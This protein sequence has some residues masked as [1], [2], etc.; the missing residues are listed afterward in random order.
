MAKID[1]E[2]ASRHAA[3]AAASAASG[4]AHWPGASVEDIGSSRIRDGLDDAAPVARESVELSVRG[5]IP[6]FNRPGDLANLLADMGQLE[7]SGTDAEVGAEGT[8]EDSRRVDFAVHLSLVV[9]DNAST[10]PIAVDIGSSASLPRDIA[11]HVIRSERNLGGS[12]GF[13]AGLRQAVSEV[14]REPGGVNRH[15]FVWL[16]DSD[17]R[18]KP[19]TLVELVRSMLRRP[20]ACAV[21]SAVADPETGRVFEVGGRVSRR[22]GRFHPVLRGVGGAP[23]ETDCEYAAACSVLVRAGA[24]RRTGLMPDVFLNADDVDWFIRM[25]RATG[26]RVLASSRS[27]VLH[28]KFDRFALAARYYVARNA[29]GPLRTLELALRVKV[30]RGMREVR[31]AV[32]CEL[33]GRGDLAR[34][35]LRGLA[36]AARSDRLAG[37]AAADRVEHERFAP[38]DQLASRLAEIGALRDLGGGSGR[39]V[40]HA[41]VLRELAAGELETL[42][43]QIRSIDALLPRGVT[44]RTGAPLNITEPLVDGRRRAAA[45]AARALG[46]GTPGLAI[47][48]AKHIADSMFA[49]TWTVQVIPDALP[50]KKAGFVVRRC[51]AVDRCRILARAAAASARG[52][53]LAIRATISDAGPVPLEQAAEHAGDDEARANAESLSIIVLSYNRREMLGATLARLDAMA[54]LRGAEIIVVDNGSADGSADA[55]RAACPRATV[56]PLATNMG[57]A[58]LNEGVNAA[59]REF[60]LVLD[61]DAWPEPGVLTS[62]LS[63]LRRRADVDAVALHPLH[64]VTKASEWPFARCEKAGTPRISDRWPVMGCGNLVRRSV[65]TAVGGYESEY[66]LYRNDTDLALKILAQ[67]GARGVYFDSSWVVWHDSPAAA[68]KSRRW[69]FLATRNWIWTARRHGRGLS[70]LAGLVLGWMWAHKTAGLAA[71]KHWHTLRGAA[72]GVFTSPPPL[73]SGITRRGRHFGCLIRMHA[74]RVTRPGR[75]TPS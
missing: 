66:F 53:A 21:G 5:V 12:G 7:R 63:L 46:A 35:H 70:G 73:A 18:V 60:V 61:D 59:G 24:I 39:I 56:V 34:L 44:A 51:A 25:G 41:R 55:A 1:A 13:N 67:P 45:M 33:M 27:I 23:P 64:P 69:H 32:G 28:P 58:A 54:E 52:A 30:R 8:G 11:C 19:D 42:T 16:V 72:A 48:H 75:S 71:G 29:L 10:P 36:D 57:V 26:Q 3:G 2:G 40:V 65:W 37:P 38:L 6:C 17:A 22:D 31:R 50:G 4:S 9:V 49:G 68:A 20:D 43:D 62:A 47:V 14:I 15:A 74:A